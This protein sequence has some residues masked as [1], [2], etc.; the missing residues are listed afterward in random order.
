MGC[1]C[2][3]RR[4]PA[5][6]QHPAPP[7]PKT[8]QRTRR[9]RRAHLLQQVCHALAQA[10]LCRALGAL[11]VVLGQQVQQLGRH[12]RLMHV[13]AK[14]I[15]VEELGVT[16]LPH[17][18][19]V[20][21]GQAPQPLLQNVTQAHLAARRR[22]ATL[23][24]ACARTA[25]AAAAAGSS[26]CAVAAAAR[27]CCRVLLRRPVL[28]RVCCR[29]GTQCVQVHRQQRDALACGRVLPHRP[30]RR[31]T[32]LRVGQGCIRPPA[33]TLL[34]L[35]QQ[36]QQQQHRWADVRRWWC[37]QRRL[38]R[39][40]AAAAAAAAPIAGCARPP[41]AHALWHCRLRV[42]T[43]TPCHMVCTLRARNARRAAAAARHPLAAAAPQ[44]PTPRR[45]PPR[46]IAAHLRGGL[47]ARA[48]AR[49]GL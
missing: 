13:R 39:P 42:C 49:L 38:P 31:H 12:V 40:A 30:H 37:S 32:V 4:P 26:C 33:A 44:P 8:Q 24:A 2:T 45:P 48:L 11:G 16:I 17:L 9:H 15:L 34:L 20:A 19:R 36:Q 5:G 18:P 3:N 23:V 27:L 46:P 6:H 1:A 25:V 28:L 22:P 35:Q 29:C 41:R 21:L 10:G 47:L 43:H 7:P 14:R